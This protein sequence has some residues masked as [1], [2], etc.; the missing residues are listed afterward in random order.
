MLVCL[1][2]LGLWLHTL[3]WGIGI[4][5]LVMPRRYRRFWPVLAL[6]AGLTL[7]SMVVWIG[8]FLDLPGTNSYGRPAELIPLL[9]LAPVCFRAGPRPLGAELLRMSG[10]LA[11][12]A[13]ALGALILPYACNYHG[14]TTG[15]IG[16][17]DAADYAAGAR[18]FMEF[19]RS[20]RMGF[21]GLTEVTRVMSV[22]HFFDFYLRL[23]HF[24]PCAITALNGTIFGCAPYEIIGVLVA[25]FLASAVPIVFWIA[26]DLLGLRS[27]PSFGIALLF[28]FSPVN[29]YAVYQTAMA[30]LLAAQAIGLLTWSAW[31]LWRHGVGIKQGGSYAGLLGLTYV[32]ILGS[33]SFIVVVCLIPAVVLVAGSAIRQR[34]YDRFGRW[35]AW[36]HLPLVL[37]ATLFLPRVLSIMERFTAFKKYDEGWKIPFLWPEGWLGIVKGPLLHPLD[38]PYHSLAIV[39]LAAALVVAF[40]GMKTRRSIL[41]YRT[42][43]LAV[44]AL[45]GCAYLNWRGVHWGHG[46][47]RSYLAYK[48]FCVFYPGILPGLCLWMLLAYRKGLQRRFFWVLLALVLF[49]V[50]RVDWRF[51]RTMV[52][53]PLLV[54]RGLLETRRVE[55]NPA[56][57]SLNLMIPDMWSRLWANSFLLNKPH[58]FPTHTYEGRLNTPLRGQWD[59]NGGLVTVVL[60]ASDSLPVNQTYSLA[61]TA[62]PY[63]VRVTLGDGWHETEHLQHTF[64][65]WIWS[66]GDATVQILN[67]HARALHVDFRFRVRSR[68]LRDI[69]FWLRDRKIAEADLD[70]TLRSINLPN[71]MID[72]GMNQIELRSSLPPSEPGPEEFR[73]LGFGLF[74]LTVNVP[75][76]S[77]RP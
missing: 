4:A 50:L 33:Y 74:G 37:A 29:W 44:P 54:D 56:V 11:A 73:R 66:R 25:V 51:A 1:L 19:A 20:D 53:P 36:I 45:L 52:N 2:A 18:S 76:S 12:S 60:P 67:P 17:C 39:L 21:M 5:W 28:G 23:M 77:N 46:E 42:F 65:H 22:D 30:Q 59:L 9:L 27:A 71:V 64:I 10:V 49:G 3:Y 62:S 31:S 38:E 35:L 43:C 26:R 61:R 6:P 48:L 24:T 57:A 40:V 7:Q 58:Y 8:A 41:L 63:F 14:L 34:Q 68:S 47:N 16:S 70:T 72:P 32:L 13:L 15:S 69:Q 75:E 55:N